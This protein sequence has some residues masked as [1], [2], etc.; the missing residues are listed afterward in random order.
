MLLFGVVLGRKA[1]PIV[2]YLIVLL[3]VVGVALFLYKD[4]GSGHH[5]NENG[6]QWR[7]F[8]FMGLGEILVVSVCGVSVCVCVPHSLPLAW[9]Q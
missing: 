2:K 7:L 3:I 5:S 9:E 8:H 6:D 1:Y 4:G